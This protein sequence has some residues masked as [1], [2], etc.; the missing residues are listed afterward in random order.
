[1][2]TPF[3]DEEF[4]LVLVQEIIEHLL[5]CQH[6]LR[7]VNRVL[8]NGGYFY[9]TTPNLTG[10]IDGFFYCVE[11]KPLA[12]TWDKESVDNSRCLPLFPESRCP[13]AWACETEPELGAAHHD[14]GKKARSSSAAA[15][16]Q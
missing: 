12:M 5:D 14:L 2:Q 13:S 3:D 1:L 11:K 7:E 6:L 16:V 10:L 15:L 4:D 9:L 8:R